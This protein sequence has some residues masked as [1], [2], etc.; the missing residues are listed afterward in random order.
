[1]ERARPPRGPAEALAAVAAIGVADEDDDGRR[2]EKSVLTFTAIF[3]AVVVTPWALF[4]YALGIPLAAAVPTAY[5]LATVAGLA[6]L[7]RTRDD[8][9]FRRSQ[10]AMFLT[11]PPLVHVALG[12]F[13]NSSA[14]ILFAASAPV[15]ALSFSRI[16]RPGL[17]FAAFIAIV[18]AMV[19]LEPVLQARAPRLDAWVVTLFFAVNIASVATIVFVA[20]RAYVRSR[21]RFADALARERDRS[22]GILRNV[23]PGPIADR[24]IAGEHPIADRFDGVGV[25]IADIVDFT[26]LSE[27]MSADELVHDLNELLGSF[28]A[29]AERLGVTKVKTI[30][31]AYLAITGGP[32]GRAD[33]DALA[34]FA[35][36]L[37]ELAGSGAIGGR[38]SV[39]VRIGMDVGTVVAGVIG[40]SRFLWDVYGETVNTASR[41]ESTAPPGTIQVTDRV[42]A[43][44]SDRFRLRP[45]GTLDIKGLGAVHTSYLEAG[46]PVP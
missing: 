6:H 21:D 16:R 39:R 12:G 31:D 5:V 33:L 1:M 4:Y 29:L 25:L 15:G 2:M 46:D 7:R 13:A 45:R 26:S 20:M 17:V 38:D 36:G 37:R 23:L 11:F 24:L 18:V 3:T 10:L 44:L 32:D 34:D 19:P 40:E 8:R 28:D 43:A 35:L 14:V 30:G 42:A 9:W 41:M 27:T 22:D